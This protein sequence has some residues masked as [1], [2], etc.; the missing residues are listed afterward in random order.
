MPYMVKSDTILF[1]LLISEFQ[2]KIFLKKQQIDFYSKYICIFVW[3]QT[4]LN[5]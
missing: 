4:K 5:E 3:K 1:Y 2:N